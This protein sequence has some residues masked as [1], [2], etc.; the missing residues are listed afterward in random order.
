MYEIRLSTDVWL[1]V[2]D[3]ATPLYFGLPFGLIPQATRDAPPHLVSRDGSIVRVVAYAYQ[4]AGGTVGTDEATA[5]ALG[6]NGVYTELG[7]LDF[8][9]SDPG[10]SPATLVYD[11]A[12]IAIAQGDLLDARI[13]PSAAYV[14]NPNFVRFVVM[15]FVEDVLEAAA[16]VAQ[17]V[18]IAAVAASKANPAGLVRP[19][20]T[21]EA[22]IGY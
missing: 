11:V 14:T 17:D 4:P 21:G 8:S 13:I 6:I 9:T 19:K 1:N 22:G 3:N 12:P 18:S 5:M 15:L 10:V 16:E 7:D 2:P 20:G